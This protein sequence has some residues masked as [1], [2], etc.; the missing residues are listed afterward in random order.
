MASAIWRAVAKSIGGRAAPVRAAPTK[1]IES[2][3][4]LKKRRA[5]SDAPYLF[6]EDLR[7]HRLAKFSRLNHGLYAPQI[8]ILASGL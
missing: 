4:E 2:Q 8:N 7:W 6:A 3:I 5:R 1:I